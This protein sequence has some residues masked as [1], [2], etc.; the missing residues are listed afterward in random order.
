M[1]DWLEKLLFRPD[2]PRPY[3]LIR[4]VLGVVCFLNFLFYLPYAELFYSDSGFYPRESLPLFQNDVYP[5][6]LLYLSGSTVWVWLVSIASLMVSLLFAVGIK[7]RFTGPLLWLC[8]ASFVHRNVFV[9]DGSFT[10]LLQI[11]IIMM[12]CDSGAIWSWDS[13]HSEEAQ[14]IIYSWVGFA[15]RFQLGL[16]YIM[17]GIY[18]LMGAEWVSGEAMLH[19]LAQPAWRRFDMSWLLSFEWVVGALMLIGVIVPWWELLF[20]LMA[21]NQ[22][23]RWFA[24]GFGVFLHGSQFFTINTALFVPILLSLYLLYLPA[25]FFD[26]VAVRVSKFRSSKA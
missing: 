12:L 21:L 9:A 14:P 26:D 16:I 3:A 19:V 11:M 8:L 15:L 4:I 20:P 23:T 13:K 1:K 25:E 17:S 24:L 18:K 6:S 2:D 5:V 7:V 10:L 22:W